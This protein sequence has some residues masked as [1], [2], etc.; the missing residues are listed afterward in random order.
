[1]P[2]TAAVFAPLLSMVI[3]SGTPCWSMGALEE[4]PRRGV[5]SVRT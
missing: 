1:M 3:F 5:V 4:R 2:S